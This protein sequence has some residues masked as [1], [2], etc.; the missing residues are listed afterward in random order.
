MF[1]FRIAPRTPGG[2]IDRQPDIVPFAAFCQYKVPHPHPLGFDLPI[3]RIRHKL[4]PF[5]GLAVD[6]QINL[7]IAQIDLYGVNG[8]L[9][10][11]VEFKRLDFP[12]NG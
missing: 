11:V 7:G 10:G 6:Y 3:L 9:T 1:D 5:F 2:S 12:S 4:V 8:E